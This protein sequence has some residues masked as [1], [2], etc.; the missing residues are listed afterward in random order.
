MSA[1]NCL[2]RRQ[3]KDFEFVVDYSYDD[4]F[5][6]RNTGT[7]KFNSK[8]GAG[9]H[10]FTERELAC[11]SQ[12]SA[13]IAIVDQFVLRVPSNEGRYYKTTP[14]LIP[15]LPSASAINNNYKY[16]EF[17]EISKN[18]VVFTHYNHADFIAYFDGFVP[19]VYF[20]DLPT[21]Q[22]P[23]FV[24][25]KTQLLPPYTTSID[26]VLPANYTPANGT[27]YARLDSKSSVVNFLETGLGSGAIFYPGAPNDP[28][29]ADNKIPRLFATV[30]DFAAQGWQSFHCGLDELPH[31]TSTCNFLSKINDS[32]Y[33]SAGIYTGDGV[34]DAYAYTGARNSS[35]GFLNVPTGPLTYVTTQSPDPAINYVRADKTGCCRVSRPLQVALIT[36]PGVEQFPEGFNWIPVDFYDLN[37]GVNTA[38]F[39]PD[40]PYPEDYCIITITPTYHD[41]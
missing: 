35:I 3:L 8:S 26:L 2:N 13:K 12:L 37:L 23:W 30:E 17:V 40:W 4:G 6:I 19:P 25:L 31:S 32:E 29:F 9:L 24:C 33:I 5:G 38:V 10:Q 34:D 27:V 16:K 41:S 18:K 39:P 22:F 36:Y 21:S 15:L 1:Q 11:S 7:A 20:A 14:N 28:D